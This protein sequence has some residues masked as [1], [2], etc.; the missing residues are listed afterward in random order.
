MNFH[1]QL[2]SPTEGE[3]HFFEREGNYRKGFEF[4]FNQMP[5]VDPDQIV[6]EKTPD[7]MHDPK[8]GWKIENQ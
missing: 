3:L 4:Y 2:K 5:F 8:E 6:F 7:Y 1:P